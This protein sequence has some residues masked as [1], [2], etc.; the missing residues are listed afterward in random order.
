M[1]QHLQ[2]QTQI[3]PTNKVATIEQQEGEQKPSDLG[4]F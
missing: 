1:N 3:K 4:L 2:K